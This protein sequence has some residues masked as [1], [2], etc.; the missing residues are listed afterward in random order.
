MHPVC[1]IST[2]NTVVTVY[3]TMSDCIIRFSP[4]VNSFDVLCNHIAL[5]LSCQC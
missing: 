2:E 5:L 4:L 1:S 3:I